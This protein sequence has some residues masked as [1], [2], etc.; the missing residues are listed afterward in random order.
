MSYRDPVNYTARYRARR[1]A[2]I[3]VRN[4]C[5]QH[6]GDRS[7]CPPHLDEQ[8]IRTA[9]TAAGRRSALVRIGAFAGVFLLHCNM[10]TAGA[11]EK[12]PTEALIEPMRGRVEAQ[13]GQPMHRSLACTWPVNGA[14]QGERIED[15]IAR[16]EMALRLARAE[17]KVNAAAK[18]RRR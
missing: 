7:L 16:L 9:K 2:G 4:G 8:R 17:A 12:R 18:R 1:Q 14:V 13:S 15:R 11:E 10:Q 6:A 5:G 3:C